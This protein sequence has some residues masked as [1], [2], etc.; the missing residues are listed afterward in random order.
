MVENE[1]RAP[2]EAALGTT[3][4]AMFRGRCL[5][6]CRV[7][8]EGGRVRRMKRKRMVSCTLGTSRCFEDRK[9]SR[10][11]T[12]KMVERPSRPRVVRS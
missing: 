12:E 9:D 4:V 8:F 1:E 10:V 7:I 11:G 3:C 2:Q 6:G 5:L